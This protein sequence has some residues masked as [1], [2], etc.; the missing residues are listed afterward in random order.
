M[1][2]IG[3]KKKVVIVREGSLESRFYDSWIGILK[4]A[5]G[6]DEKGKTEIVNGVDE[7]LKKIE[8]GFIDTLVFISG[9]MFEE[10]EK[11]QDKYPLVNVVLLFGQ[12]SRKRPILIDK[13]WGLSP[14]A[15]QQ[16]ILP[17]I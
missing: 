14:K 7:A 13:G 8:Q 4:R 12:M 2:K 5:I 10:A 3:T 15:I 6:L 11:I 1:K 9:S 17:Y 16:I